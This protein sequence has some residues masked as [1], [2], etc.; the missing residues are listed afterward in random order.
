MRFKGP[1]AG[2]GRNASIAGAFVGSPETGIAPPAGQ[3]GNFAVTGAN[4]GAAGVFAAKK[5]NSRCVHA[6]RPLDDG[7]C[8][9]EDR[10]E[11]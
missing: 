10:E 3:I 5:N 8:R 9:H 11:T 7:R 2:G 6:D 4:Y 1:L